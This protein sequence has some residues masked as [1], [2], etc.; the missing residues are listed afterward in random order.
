[1]GPDFEDARR[2]VRSAFTEVR[3]IRPEG[4][5][6]TS[7]EIFVIGLGRKVPAAPAAPT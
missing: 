3:G 2:R 5:R 7:Y 1:M 4:T 6:A